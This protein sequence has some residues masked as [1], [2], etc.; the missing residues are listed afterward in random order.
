MFMPSAQLGAMGPMGGQQ[1]SPNPPLATMFLGHAAAPTPVPT[2]PRAPP[3]N[4]ACHSCAA[5]LQDKSAFHCASCSGRGVPLLPCASCGGMFYATFLINGGESLVCGTCRADALRLAFAPARGGFEPSNFHM[6]LKSSSQELPSRSRL[7]AMLEKAGFG[8]VARIDFD[9][10]PDEV[11]QSRHALRDGLHQVVHRRITTAGVIL[12]DPSRM[13]VVFGAQR[14]LS[15]DGGISIFPNR[16]TDVVQYAGGG[17][18][19][20]PAAA[21]GP[22]P[23][24]MPMQMPM[25]GGFYPYGPG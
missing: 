5:P 14:Y 24:S 6:I 22:V 15:L 4:P 8:A 18:A 17:G 13:S 9:Y 12:V 20:G 7:S 23:M 11:D 25:G 10:D 3:A 16:A 21:S 1:L 19:W 2:A